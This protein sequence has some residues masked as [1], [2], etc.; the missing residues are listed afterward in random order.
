MSLQIKQNTLS[1]EIKKKIFQGF[2]E[3]AIEATG[4]NGLSEEPISFEVFDRS[5]FVG[6]IVVQMFW[7]QLHIKYLFVEKKYRGQ[8][9]ATQLMNHALEFGKKRGCHFAF[10]ETMSFQALEFYRRCGFVID[11]SREGYAKNTAFHYLKKNLTNSLVPA[12]IMR[13]GAYG[14]AIKNGKILLITQER[15]PHQGKFDLPGGRIEFGETIEQTLRREFLEEVSMHFESM[16]FLFNLTERV[17]VSNDHDPYSF[18]CIGLIYSISGL[19]PS[20][21]V[22]TNSLGYIWKEMSEIK[23]I[24]ASQFVWTIIKYYA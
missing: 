2:S 21:E 9:I 10:V 18:H 3:Q 11:F 16:E 17:D 15:G 7:E 22:S 23:E 6:A 19:Y 20:N 14:V 4:I 12:Q 24:E 13:T 5:E 1:D 8:G